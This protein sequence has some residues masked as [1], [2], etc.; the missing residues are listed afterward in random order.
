MRYQKKEISRVKVRNLSVATD[1]NREKCRSQP[2]YFAK[3][4]GC[5]R[6]ILLFYFNS[7]IISHRNTP[8]LPATMLCRYW[9]FNVK[10]IMYND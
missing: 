6:Q 4:V 8:H 7:K 9:K 10:R 3:S 5:N 2:T 1:K